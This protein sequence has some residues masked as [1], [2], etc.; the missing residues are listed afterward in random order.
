MSNAHVHDAVRE[1]YGEIA[2]AVGTSVKSGSKPDSCCGPAPCGCGVDDARA[3]LTESGL[4]VDRLA[5]EVDGHV[6][7]A[8]IRARKPEAAGAS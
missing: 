8:F 7:S 3:F 2:R 4:G 6:A 5:G 1:K